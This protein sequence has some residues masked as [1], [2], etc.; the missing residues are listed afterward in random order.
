MPNGYFQE[1][2][3]QKRNIRFPFIILTDVKRNQ[4]YELS[5]YS[6][7]GHE[8]MVFGDKYE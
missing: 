6:W 7:K 1:G 3:L 2:R 4:P 5:K 8:M